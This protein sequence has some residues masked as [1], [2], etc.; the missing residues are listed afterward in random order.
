MPVYRSSS[1]STGR[2]SSLTLRKNFIPPLI[3]TPMMNGSRPVPGRIWN[4]L[5]TT[6][7]MAGVQ[8]QQEKQG[9]FSHNNDKT[10]GLLEW[11]Q[12]EEDL[13]RVKQRRRRQR[14]MPD[15]S[16]GDGR[17]VVPREAR[18]GGGCRCSRLKA[19]GQASNAPC[20]TERCAV[21]VV[22]MPTAESSRVGRRRQVLERQEHS[23]LHVGPNFPFVVVTRHGAVRRP[24]CRH[25]GLVL[26]PVRFDVLDP[27][28]AFSPLPR[29]EAS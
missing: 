9:E 24:L 5:Q 8:L 12:Q 18:Q 20:P 26:D 14:V 23:P 3:G 28:H 21:R 22:G 1:G 29:L 13:A 15:L 7:G 16:R 17:G 2:R 6:K 10:P 25:V 4:S 11:R 27:A 19:D